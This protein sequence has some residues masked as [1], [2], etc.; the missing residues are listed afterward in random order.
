MVDSAWGPAEDARLAAIREPLAMVSTATACQM[1][2]SHGWR[3]SYM[4]KLRP[5]SPLGL[6]VRLVGRA[7]T[8]RY[9]ARRGPEGPPDPAARRISPEIVLIEAMRPGDVLCID[10]LGVTTAGIIGD[11][12]SARLK[13]NGAIAAV[14]HGV[15]RDSP[16]I[17]EL[18]LPVFSAGV[19]PSH[20]G[21]DLVPVDFDL[22]I[23]MA[24]VH[25]TP[26]DVILADDEGVM[27]MPLDLAEYVA[28]QG[29][30]KEHLEGWIRG[31]VLAGG[32]IHDYYPPSPE[33]LAEYERETGRQF[34]QSSTPASNGERA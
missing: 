21:R 33:K 27:A 28:S 3:N 31:K 2:I 22:S 6:G 24:G 7:R 11:I 23:D 20:S 4:L 8:C 18:G 1:L 30:P 13:A 34:D 29:P 10:A 25:V 32:S 14:I 17:A 12:L 5:L 26:G 16:Y 9:L 19:H 15:V